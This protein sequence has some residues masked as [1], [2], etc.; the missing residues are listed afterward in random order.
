[1]GELGVDLRDFVPMADANARQ[2]RSVSFMA[3][4][5]DR[6]R[7]VVLMAFAD[8]PRPSARHAIA[9]LDRLGIR[10]IMLTGD[11]RGAAEAVAREIGLAAF[12]AGVLPEDK[13]R[14]V[15]ELRGRH[16]Q[17]AMVGD[18]VNDAP[19]LAAADLGIAMGTGTD[20][21]IEAAGIALMRSDPLAVADAI[22]IARRTQAKIRQNLFW[23][24]VYNVAFV[25]LAALGFL[26]PMS[27]GAAMAF[28]SVSVVGNALLLRRW[29]PERPETF[30]GGKK[31]SQLSSQG[32]A[33]R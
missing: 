4:I 17:V 1:M 18:G 5:T 30:P 14:M 12:E 29:R 8:T 28:S 21:A 6:P 31:F 15:G 19:A 2:G 3:D 23:A 24:F 13:A 26:N 25:P 10:S 32:E 22:E 11:N 27:A 9:K 20:V 33:R 7:L 16:G